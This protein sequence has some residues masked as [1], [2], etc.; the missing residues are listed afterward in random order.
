MWERVCYVS[1]DWDDIAI[2]ATAYLLNSCPTASASPAGLAVSPLLRVQTLYYATPD[3]LHPEEVVPVIR[4]WAGFLEGAH[5][6]T[7]LLPGGPE[8][9]FL[10]LI[11]LVAAV[12]IALRSQGT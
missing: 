5:A 12:I 2:S 7:D 3:A 9:W 8:T 11:V 6:Y 10:P 4:P 1:L